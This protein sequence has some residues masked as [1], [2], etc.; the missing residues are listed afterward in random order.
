MVAFAEKRATWHLQRGSKHARGR[1]VGS[2]HEPPSCGVATRFCFD[3]HGLCSEVSGKC[4]GTCS[5]LTASLQ[6]FD[7]ALDE[8]LVMISVAAEMTTN[9]VARRA[10]VTP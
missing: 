7:F 2:S 5:W 9:F 6:P 4:V 10:V 1:A 3:A 8:E